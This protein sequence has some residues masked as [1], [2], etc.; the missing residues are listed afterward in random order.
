MIFQRCGAAPHQDMGVVGEWGVR[1]EV[2][3]CDYSLAGATDGVCPDCANPHH[4]CLFC[5]DSVA[6]DVPGW[7]LG[8]NA[9][10]VQGTAGSWN[11]HFGTMIGT[12]G[13]SDLPDSGWCLRRNE[14]RAAP[15]VHASLGAPAD[16]TKDSYEREWIWD[17]AWGAQPGSQAELLQELEGIVAGRDVYNKIRHAR[18]LVLK[19]A[20][21]EMKRTGVREPVFDEAGTPAQRL[22]K[23]VIDADWGLALLTAGGGGGGRAA[24]GGGGGAGWLTDE[25]ERQYE[26]IIGWNWDRV[27]V[28]AL[29]ALRTRGTNPRVFIP[30]SQGWAGGRMRVLF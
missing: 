21:E 18:A 20:D 28:E 10:G 30:H 5:G 12:W 22:F 3:D 8:H 19:L 25:E 9:P 2:G 1:E 29:E 11:A 23:A 14:G 27:K 13:R 17:P 6:C 16:T 15:V 7:S 24:A 26:A 4:F